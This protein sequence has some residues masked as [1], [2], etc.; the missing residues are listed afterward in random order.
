[1]EGWDL[2][3]ELLLYDPERRITAREALDH[4]YF[5]TS[6]QT[7]TATGGKGNLVDLV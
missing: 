6:S 7:T 3:S 1:M 2:M 4:P 5:F